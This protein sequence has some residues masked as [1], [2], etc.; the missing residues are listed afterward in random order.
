MC[1]PHPIDTF[2]DKV[3]LTGARDRIAKRTYIRAQGYPQPVFDKAY[4][5]LKATP[6]WNVYEV[7]CGHDVMVDEPQWLV[8]TLVKAS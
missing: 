8:D 7:N 6:G 1:T 4:E 5:K 2:I 3:K